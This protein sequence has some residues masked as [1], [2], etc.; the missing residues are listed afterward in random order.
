[1]IPHRYTLALL[2]ASNLLGGCGSAARNGTAFQP[3]PVPKLRYETATAQV[4]VKDERKGVSR[5]RI[6]DTPVFS[7]PGDGEARA[8]PASPEL[9]AEMAAL[10]KRWVP[11]VGSDRLYFEVYLH[12]ADAGWAAHWF[13]EDAWATVELRVCAI[14]GTDN[15]VL[16]AGRAWSTAD[17][18]SADVTDSEPAQLFDLAVLSAWG[19]WVQSDQVISQVN[20]ALAEKRRWGRLLHPAVC[21]H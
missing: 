4:F 16:L 1:M 10:L 11:R 2:L 19:R 17:S 14:D 20:R 18:S 8:L 7:W 15:G 9:H 13:S 21:E 6:F 12:R 3:L 5:D